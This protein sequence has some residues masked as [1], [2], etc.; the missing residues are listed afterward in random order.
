MI[1]IIQNGAEK[2][3]TNQETVQTIS[4]FDTCK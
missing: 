3:H 2:E 4:T 1:M